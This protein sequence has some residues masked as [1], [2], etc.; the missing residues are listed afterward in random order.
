MK[1]QQDIIV[2]VIIPTYNQEKYI[3]QA[4]DSVLMQKTQYKME[5]LVGEDK[6]TDNTKVI[7]QEYEKKHPGQINVFYRE[8][9]LS[10]AILD[11]S[12]DLRRKAIGKYIITLEG[13]DFW[14]DVNKIETQVKFLENHTEYIAVSHLCQVVDE[15]SRLI[16]EDYPSCKDEEY[17]LKHYL[18]GIYPGQ[19][20]TV[21][22][23]NFY[24]ED[25]FDFTILEKHLSPSDKLMYF[26]LVTNGRVKCIQKSMS[27]YRHV[28]K[29]GASYSAN[30]KYNF[31]EDE[32]WHFELL[33]FSKQQ[34]KG[35]KCVE[36]LYFGCLIHGIKKKAISL[37]KAVAYMNNLDNKFTA[38]VL[39]L[40][41]MI[42]IHILGKGKVN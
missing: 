1:K 34:K 4:L 28:R 19:L 31:V 10:N 35:V 36:A 7:L 12:A 25:L 23:R 20:T 16:N 38:V 37:R 9:N 3:E 18:D 39:F 40:K 5:I 27:A 21:M 24:K 17:R 11:N 32:H 22:C 30:Y 15:N 26:A 29:G 13:D 2:S 14:T 41:R 42:D 33:L 8:H 6:S